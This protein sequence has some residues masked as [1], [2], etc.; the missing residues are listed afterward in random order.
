[1]IDPADLGEQPAPGRPDPEGKRVRLEPGHRGRFVRTISVRQCLKDGL[2]S[3]AQSLNGW[4]DF[5]QALGFEKGGFRDDQFARRDGTGGEQTVVLPWRFGE[6]VGWRDGRHGRG[7]F[8]KW[9]VK[10]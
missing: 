3:C 8:W 5:E 6:T 1:M 7:I 10:E 2:V 9:L 4:P